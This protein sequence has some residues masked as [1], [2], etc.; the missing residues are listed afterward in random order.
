MVVEPYGLTWV[1]LSEPVSLPRLCWRF[2][3]G[4]RLHVR[5]W[6]K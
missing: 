6:K 2:L 1:I 5:R 4:L 3:I